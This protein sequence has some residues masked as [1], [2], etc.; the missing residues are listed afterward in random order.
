MRALLRMAF[1]RCLRG[2]SGKSTCL[3]LNA[4]QLYVIKP[5]KEDQTVV[6][7]AK[8]RDKRVVRAFPAL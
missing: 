8:N 4:R 7:A 3:Y 2:K 5:I 1:L 6:A